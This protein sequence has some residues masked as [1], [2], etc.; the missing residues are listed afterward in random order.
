MYILRPWL[1]LAAVASLAVE[2]V[3]AHSVQRN[4]LRHVSRVEDAVLHTHRV[5]AHSTFEL[6]FFL[7]DHNDNRRRIRLSLEPN[8]DIIP[9]GATISTIE[10]DGTITHEP[11]NR[12]DYRIFK[13]D[14]FREDADSGERTH[15]G[16]ARI[17]L[18]HDGSHPLFE[19]GFRVDNDHH[20]IQ[21]SRNYMQTRVPEDP[22]IE[23]EDEGVLDSYE[24]MIVWKDSDIKGNDHFTI[25]HDH[26]FGFGDPDELKRRAVPVEAS[27]HSDKLDFNNEEDH[28]VYRAMMTRDED[29]QEKR[30]HAMSP[31]ALFGRQNLDG[32]TSGNGAGVNLAG[33]IGSTQG[34]PS[35]RKVALVGI[36]TDCTYG[37]AFPAR[38]NISNN[39][40]YQ[41]NL[42]SKLYEDSFNISLG[43]QN[44]TIQG[45]NCPARANPDSAAPWN[46]DCNSGI[47]IT[48]RLNLFSRWR[49][50]TRDSNAFWTLLTTCPTDS[51]VGLAW[52]GQVCVQGSQQNPNSN[53]NETISSA[54]VVVRTSTEWQ[55]I[56]HEVGHTFGA[57]HDCVRSSCSD[58]TVTRQQCCPLST[59]QCDAG[60]EFIMN[61]STGSRIQRFSACS[62]GNICQAIGRVSIRTSCLRDNRDVPPLFTGSQCGNGIVEAGEQCDCG[63]PQGCGNNP[64]CDP[65]TCRFRGQ[66]V[67][68]FTNEDCCTR[69]CS[70]ATNGT[71]CRSSTGSCDPAETCPGNAASCPADATAD[72]GTSCGADGQGLSCAS[73]QCTS[74]DLQCRTLMGARTGNDTFSCGSQGCQ[75]SCQSPQFGNDRCLTMMQ[76]FRDG[77]PCNGGGRCGNGQCRNATFANE[78][79]TWIREN[80]AIFIPVVV[81]VGVLL[82]LA[83]I[84][85]CFARCRRKRRVAKPKTRPPVAQTG[86]WG[87]HPGGG[88]RSQQP[89][90]V[91]PVSQQ[92]G[93]PQQPPPMYGAP[94]RSM[95][96]R[97]A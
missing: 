19:G 74:R 93:G 16:W 63:G 53:S 45:N 26:G 23:T 83:V 79:G 31:R 34:C 37:Q 9:R 50:Q 64:C 69:Q 17:M 60:G 18:H 14:V 47:T 38:T 6:S 33:S 65:T 77:T 21:L 11:L 15:A 2:H 44:L 10:E 86:G 20:H 52:L 58:G 43:I 72:D 57:V 87:N 22:I 54:N 80:Q 8:N 28:P 48:D 88:R 12:L 71:V 75:L 67:C 66:A 46:L 13:G 35:T 95:S 30:W 25:N 7:R 61:P 41:M 94:P 49:G 1:A 5:H 97:Y 32:T 90:W 36:A 82:I 59:S 56:A 91:P 70:F 76:Y 3:A 42:V 96:M 24:H 62:I 84:T 89:G 78:V 4:P 39:V 55:V 29:F 73:G 85:C 40:I 51:A 81:V 68:D 92:R 27:C